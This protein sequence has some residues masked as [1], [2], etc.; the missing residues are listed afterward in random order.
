MQKVIMTKGLPASG[1]TTWAKQQKLKRINKD[2]LR[3]MLDNGEWSKKNENMI[4]E[5]RNVIIR[6]CL[7]YGYSVIVDDTNLAPKHEKEIRSIAESCGASFEV[8]D[9]TDVPLEEC[10]RRDKKRPNYVG[11]TVIMDMY[12]RYLKPP[13]NPLHNNPKLP[14]CI[15]CDVDGT[16]AQMN[17]RGPFEWHRV[18]EDL[19]RTHVID[20]VIGLYRPD[21]L[22]VFMSGRD[23]VCR[24]E[25]EQWLSHYMGMI[26]GFNCVLLMRPKG[27]MR[28]DTEVKKELLENN[29]SGKYRVKAVFDDRKSVCLAWKE[30][31]LGDRL[32][33]VGM[34][35]E[36]DF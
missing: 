28:P 13:Y 21:D 27:D 34:I 31:G 26:P 18:G 22:L 19:P 32:I 24:P 11:E 6:A 25:T 12:N 10:L 20:A 8:K 15:I 1:K 17:G 16:V 14:S 2:D 30:L 4:L 35:D 7:R 33:R 29:I 23:E 3:A 9:F 5:A 36:D